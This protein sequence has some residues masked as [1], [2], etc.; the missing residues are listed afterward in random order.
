[1]YEYIFVNQNVQILMISS[2]KTN[3]KI[4]GKNRNYFH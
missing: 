3:H 1:M 2:Y 4:S